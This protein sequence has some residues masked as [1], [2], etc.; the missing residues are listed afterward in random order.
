MSALNL[1]RARSVSSSGLL[2]LL[3]AFTMPQ[4]RRCSPKPDAVR[5]KVDAWRD[6]SVINRIHVH[7]S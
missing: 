2:N 3:R 5:T 7:A 4:R 1:S 6:K